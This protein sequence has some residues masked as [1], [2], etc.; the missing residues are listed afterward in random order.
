MRKETSW[1][2]QRGETYFTIQSQYITYSPWETIEGDEK[3]LNIN[4]L[5]GWLGGFVTVGWGSGFRLPQC[6]WIQIC[7]SSWKKA[8]YKPSLYD[9]GKCNEKA[10]RSHKE[11]ICQVV[12]DPQLSH[13]SLIQ[14]KIITMLLFIKAKSHW[15]GRPRHCWQVSL[16]SC[17]PAKCG[18]WCLQWGSQ[19]IYTVLFLDK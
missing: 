17:M 4:N 13:S 6:W 12:M 1:A 5:C 7:C 2:C 9:M 11:S 19:F 14:T 18:S 10:A 8:T 15:L 16:F 3:R